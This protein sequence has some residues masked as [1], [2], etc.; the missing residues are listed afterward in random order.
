MDSIDICLAD[1]GYLLKYRDP[2]LVAQNKG[3]GP[4]VDPYRSRVYETAET[5]MAGLTALL[6]LM[7]EEQASKTD[8]EFSAA[9]NEALS[10]AET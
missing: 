5:L 3:D 7:K 9:F 10:Q 1:N 4:W 8:D 6:P 2:K